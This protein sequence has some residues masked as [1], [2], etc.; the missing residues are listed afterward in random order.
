MKTIQPAFNGQPASIASV[1][2][3]AAFLAVTMSGR[4]DII[5]V[6]NWN[7]GTISKFDSVTG[8]YLGIFADNIH[9]GR[10]SGTGNTL[11]VLGNQGPD[12]FPF[13]VE[14]EVHGDSPRERKNRWRRRETT[15]ALGRLKRRDKWL[16]LP[17]GDGVGGR[18][19][20]HEK[21]RRFGALA[22]FHI[23]PRKRP[24]NGAI[25]SFDK[26][27]RRQRKIWGR[28]DFQGRTIDSEW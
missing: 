3:L 27:R 10:R 16:S 19:R 25:L 13:C 4:A 26:L 23:R 22:F 2:L 15:E 28:D 18:G 5:Y 14:N 21:F 8:R 12:R 17:W 20:G 6:A 1:S 24:G 9:A 7:T 11:Q